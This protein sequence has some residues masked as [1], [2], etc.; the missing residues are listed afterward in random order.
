MSDDRGVADAA[1]Q[2]HPPEPEPAAGTVAVDATRRTYLANERTF[3]AWFRTALA[4]L[5]LAITIGRVLPELT[6]GQA[7]PFQLVGLGFGLL[8]LFALFY[9]GFRE[10]LIDRMLAKG[11]YVP[12]PV[13][14]VA[15]MM[16]VAAIL[17][18]ALI[19]LIWAL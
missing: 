18:V 19:V 5:A 7:L 11:G 8:G 2:G 10:Q 9:G 14:A 4:C 16:G 1:P 17:G 6:G 15:L 13:Q 3:L 12:L